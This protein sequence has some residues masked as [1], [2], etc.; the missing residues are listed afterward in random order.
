VGK[1]HWRRTVRF[2]NSYKYSSY[3]I[4]NFAW[5]TDTYVPYMLPCFTVVFM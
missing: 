2:Q 4:A 5:G 3:Y 1:S